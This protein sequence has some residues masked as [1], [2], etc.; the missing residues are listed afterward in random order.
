MMPCRGGAAPAFRDPLIKIHP[1]RY[2]DFCNASMIPNDG[3][4]SKWTHFGT[5]GGIS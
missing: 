4:I 5:Q 1:P 2:A 3:V